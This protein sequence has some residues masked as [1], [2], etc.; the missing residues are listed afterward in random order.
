MVEIGDADATAW[1]QMQIVADTM[2]SVIGISNGVLDVNERYQML[3][4]ANQLMALDIE[5]V[6]KYMPRTSERLKKMGVSMDEWLG[7]NIDPADGKLY[8]IPDM[9]DPL[10][11]ADVRTSNYGE[12]NLGNYPYCIW[13]RDDILKMIYPTA[14]NEKELRAVAL[15][16]GGKLDLSDIMDIPMN[17][18]EDLYNYMVKV[19]EL[20]LQTSDG[21][22]I[23]PAHL[24]REGSMEAM[25]WSLYSAANLWWCETPLTPNNQSTGY[26]ADF[27]M[28][29][30]WKEYTNFMNKAYNENLLDKEMF[31]QSADQC[32]AKMINGEY[33]IINWW[34][35]H[36]DAR[37]RAADKGENYGYRMYP[38]FLIDLEHPQQD[39]KDIVLTLKAAWNAK[40]F[41]PGKVKPEM[42]PQLLNWIDW[43]YSEEAAVL[44]SWG[45]PDMYTGEGSERRFKPEFAGVEAYMLSGKIDEAGRDGWYYGLVNRALNN[46]NIWNYEVYG[47]A[48][49]EN[50]KYYL[51]PEYVYPADEKSLDTFVITLEAMRKY[52]LYDA[53]IKHVLK[54][55]GAISA[56]AMAARATYDAV[57]AKSAELLNTFSDERKLALLKSITDPVENFEANY[58]AYVDLVSKP[59]MLDILIQQKDAWFD[60][61]DKIDACRTVVDK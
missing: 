7:A 60:Y 15:S 1:L 39:Y 9:P 33:A 5:T 36:Q 58:K 57:A 28:T 61:L 26:F 8:Y 49:S 31:T 37:A 40:S 51:S 34:A 10:L 18:Y 38:M 45:T 41:N 54:K 29:D 30:G 46:T 53:D 12:K 24:Q 4:N 59:E 6:K 27:S 48:D 44:R 32:D 42:L 23:I 52:Y 20:N 56:E 25:V 22:K 21:K 11:S 2:P 47:L 35:P 13:L 50:Q 55:E 3:K 19:K 17:N 43:N 14:K 16:K